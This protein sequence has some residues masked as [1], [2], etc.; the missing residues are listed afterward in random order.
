MGQVYEAIDGRLREF[1]LSQPLYFVATAPSGPEGHINLSP[2]GL[3]GTL[4]VLDERR[5]AYLDYYGSGV[6]TIAHLR[7]NGR[8]VLMCCAF[9]G[10]PK[11]VRLHGTGSVVLPDDAEF[12]ALWERFDDQERTGRLARSVTPATRPVRQHGVRSIIVIEV[13]RISDSCG[14]GVPLMTLVDDRDLL[15]R[16]HERKNADDFAAYAETKNATSIDGLA[17]LEPA[18]ASTAPAS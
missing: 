1:V 9:S 16:S 7:E 11:I 8:I 15:T 13:S 6:E 3:S 17:G 10:P 5:V 2:K 18:K 14:Y 12:G 4:V